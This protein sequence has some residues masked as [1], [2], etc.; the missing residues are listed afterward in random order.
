METIQRGEALDHGH[1]RHAWGG[2]GLQQRH[3]ALKN[4]IPGEAYTR[5]GEG[6]AIVKLPLQDAAAAQK[7]YG[8]QPQLAALPAWETVKPGDIFSSIRTWRAQHSEYL[9]GDGASQ[10]LGL[11]QRLEEPGRPDIRQSNRGSG[12]GQRISPCRSLT[13]RKPV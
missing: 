12:T 3:S 6:S 2:C 8:V 13:L 4:Y 7:D 10:F 5:E 1:R 9:P 11:I